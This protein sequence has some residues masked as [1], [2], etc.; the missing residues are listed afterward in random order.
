MAKVQPPKEGEFESWKKDLLAKLRRVNVSTIFRKGFPRHDIVT[1]EV[2]KAYDSA[3]KPPSPFIC[4]LSEPVHGSNV[5]SY[6]SGTNSPFR[7]IGS[8]ALAKEGDAC[9]LRAAWDGRQTLDAEEPTQ[10][11]RA[12]RI[13]CLAGRWTAGGCGI[14]PRPR[15]ICAL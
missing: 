8:M 11:C 14:S 13:I 3:P 2:L 4:G 9:I 10:L 15:A 7:P 12:I 6:V 5:F 1:G